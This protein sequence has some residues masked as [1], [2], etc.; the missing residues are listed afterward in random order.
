MADERGDE[1]P[2]DNARL[3]IWAG[4]AFILLVALGSTGY[5][6]LRRSPYLAVAATAARPGRGKAAD[7]R[8]RPV[9]PP[10]PNAGWAR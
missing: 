9:T 7:S 8:R 6:A 2:A 1:L 5:F 4:P 3:V 10:R